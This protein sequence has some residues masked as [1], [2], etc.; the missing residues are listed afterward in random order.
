MSRYYGAHAAVKGLSFNI[1]EK[2]IVGFLGLNGAG[3]STT[4]KVLAG[5]LMPSSGQVKVNGVD[6]LDAP[7]SF[8]AKIGFLPEDPPLYPEMRVS[9]FV[10]HV[11]AI[12]GMSA[13]ELA[14]RLPEVL[15]AC[16]LSDVADREISVLSHGYRKRVGIAQAIIHTPSLVILDEPISGL[17]P[18]QIVLMREVIIGLKS[19]CTVIM[20]SHILSEISQTCDRILVLHDGAIVAEGSEE[21]LA[22]HLSRGERVEISVRGEAKAL[23]GLLKRTDF[24]RSVTI[25]E[26]DEGVVRATVFLPLERREALVSTLVH[27]GYGVQRVERG[28]SE[29]ERTFLALTRESNR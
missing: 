20:S 14:E 1:S 29:L 19:F 28:H 9:E 13:S 7:N 24:V 4:L 10:A 18:A 5:I 22:G 27:S 6:V 26:V 16:Q 11:G 21:E 25:N 17:D 15:R 23:E 3:K 8:R 2:E 12:K